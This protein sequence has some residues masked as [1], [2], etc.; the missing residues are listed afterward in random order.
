[1]NPIERLIKHYDDLAV[2]HANQ[3]DHYMK[4]AK[5]ERD[6]HPKEPFDFG[7]EIPW[8]LRESGL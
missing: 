3:S 5:Q 8:T 7:E 1:M 6:A 4:L 2:Y